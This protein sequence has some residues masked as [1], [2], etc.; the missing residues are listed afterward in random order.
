MGRVCTILFGLLTLGCGR[1]EPPADEPPS[2]GKRE[3]APLSEDGTIVLGLR[4]AGIQKAFPGGTTVLW[5]ET[6]EGAVSGEEERRAALAAEGIRMEVEGEPLELE[7]EVP[8]DLDLDVLVVTPTGDR[9]HRLTRLHPGERRGLMVEEPPTT[10][11]IEGVLRAPDG[12]PLEEG[13][14]VIPGLYETWIRPDGHF[15]FTVVGSPPP[16]SLEV[17]GYPPLEFDLPPEGESLDLRLVE[18]ARALVRVL[19]ANGF[20][21]EGLQVHATGSDS[22]PPPSS[23]DGRGRVVLEA[24]PPGELALHVRQGAGPSRRLVATSPVLR[25]G[26]GEELEVELTA[27]TSGRVAGRLVDGDGRPLGEVEVGLVVPSAVLRVEATYVGSEHVVSRRTR[28]DPDGSFLFEEVP[29][30]LW[31][32]GVVGGSWNARIPRSATI[33]PVA[34]PVTPGEPETTIQTWTRLSLSG[35]VIDTSGQGI[36]RTTVGLFP[37]DFGGSREVLTDLDGSFVVKG[38]YAGPH[39]LRVEGRLVR[40]GVRAEETPGSLTI[41]LDER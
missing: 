18:G 23:T 16:L 38:V 5:R 2:G 9:L 11:R 10:R 33:A 40:S 13:A 37:E 35:R 4:A 31:L 7:F 29:G 8:A 30:G 26:A 28:T 12:D 41:E 32:V 24:L 15:E 22:L 14:L 27:P 36:A 34:V 20:P 39:D 21:L 25:A 6:S 19:D 3:P 1:A 17:E